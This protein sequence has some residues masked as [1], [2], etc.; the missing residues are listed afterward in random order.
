M[1]QGK[2][3]NGR[4]KVKR[5]KNEYDIESFDKIYAYGDSN[6]DKPMLEMA[7]IKYFRWKKL[8]SQ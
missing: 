7:D 5:I 3:C 8:G 4:E 1:I 6:G 2:N